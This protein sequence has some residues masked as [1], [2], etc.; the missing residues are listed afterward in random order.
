MR[1]RDPGSSQERLEAVKD[2]LGARKGQFDAAGKKTCRRRQGAEAGRQLL[3]H[4]GGLC[5]VA[6][7]P[8]MSRGQTPPKGRNLLS[9]VVEGASALGSSLAGAGGGAGIRG[10]GVLS[11][12]LSWIHCVIFCQPL[13]LSGPQLLL[14]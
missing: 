1:G 2:T 8:G 12:S 14:L 9:L 13:N 7:D 3:G 4:S 5:R 6:A 10:V 11:S